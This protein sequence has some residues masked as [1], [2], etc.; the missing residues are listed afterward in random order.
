MTAPLQG[1][2]PLKLKR[3][4][5]PKLWHRFDYSEEY[6]G[7]VLVW[8]VSCALAIEDLKYGMTRSDCGQSW[9]HKGYDKMK[10]RALAEGELRKD[11]FQLEWKRIP[12]A[13]ARVVL[14]G[15]DGRREV[16][17]GSFTSWEA[18]LTRARRAGHLPSGATG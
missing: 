10:L 13:L 14:I 7:E 4:A 3:L 5:Y 12:E 8:S 1:W 6:D 15:P 2:H 11:L 9:H 16:S 18:K 17:N